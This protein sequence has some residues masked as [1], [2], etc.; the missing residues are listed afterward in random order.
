MVPEIALR[1][2]QTRTV[3]KLLS[4]WCNCIAPR[5]VPWFERP[6]AGEFI[7]QLTAEGKVDP[8][9]AERLRQWLEDGYFIVKNAVP[10]ADIDAIGALIDGLASAT[11]PVVGLKL[12]GLRQPSDP[13]LMDISHRDFL[14]RYRLEDRKRM[15][16]ES[17]WRIHGLHRWHGSVRQV[18]RNRELVRLASLVFQ[19]RAVASSSITFARGSSQGLHQD[20][21]VFHVQPR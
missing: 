8:V 2:L 17:A 1:A 11:R 9:D 14:E 20:M 7:K 15:L 10:E 6:D 12:L 18:F 19:H 4:V 5:D 13:R 16:S 3:R 21:A